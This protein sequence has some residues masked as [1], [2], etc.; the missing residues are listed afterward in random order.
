MSDQLL[1]TNPFDKPEIQPNYLSDEE[2]Q[3]VI[4]DATKLCR[5]LMQTDA[6][7]PFQVKETYPGTNT[8][9]ITNYFIQFVIWDNQFIT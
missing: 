8:K 2:D 7:K 1:T 6:L 5:R 3:R 4:L 9:M